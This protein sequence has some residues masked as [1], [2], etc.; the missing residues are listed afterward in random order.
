MSTLPPFLP[1]VF[2]LSSSLPAST[3]LALSLRFPSS[4]SCLP[5]LSSQW[6]MAER[7]ANRVE[8]EE[9]REGE[10]DC[11]CCCCSWWCEEEEEG[12]R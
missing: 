3:T 1:S 8:V 7:E 4:L 5:F 2:V 11:R 12:D 10:E 9:E 6:K